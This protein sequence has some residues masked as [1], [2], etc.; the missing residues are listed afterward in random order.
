LSLLIFSTVNVLPGRQKNAKETQSVSNSGIRFCPRKKR[1][2]V[3]WPKPQNRNKNA[4]FF[5]K[6]ISHH[7]LRRSAYWPK[8][9]ILKPVLILEKNQKTLVISKHRHIPELKLEMIQPSNMIN[10]ENANSYT[11]ILFKPSGRS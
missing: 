2:L 11:C 9:A 8:A 5:V 1:F 3:A 4:L 7:L 10:D 6:A